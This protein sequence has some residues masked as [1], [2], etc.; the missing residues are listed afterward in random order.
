MHGQVD[1][2]T[3]MGELAKHNKEDDEAGNP[4]P[5]LVCMYDFVAEHGDK[6]C[7]RCNDDDACITGDVTIDGVDE[8]R[9]D[10]HVDG[11]PAHACENVEKGNDFD[12]VKAEEVT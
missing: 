3:R 2:S 10:Y 12:A 4:G 11:R 7:S 8:L 9:A 5:E 1:E 6:E